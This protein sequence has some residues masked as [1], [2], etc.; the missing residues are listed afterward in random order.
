M[1]MSAG[2]SITAVVSKLKT[3][4]VPAELAYAP[5]ATCFM[6]YAKDLLG[7]DGVAMAAHIVAH[8]MVKGGG[9]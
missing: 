6:E 8:G 1:S 3:R 2:Y 5:V 7:T 4:E 9:L